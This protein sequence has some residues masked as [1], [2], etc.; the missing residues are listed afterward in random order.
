MILISCIR[1][2]DSFSSFF[3]SWYFW[4]VKMSRGDVKKAEQHLSHRLW[5][6]LTHVQQHRLSPHGSVFKS[7]RHNFPGVF[8]WDIFLYR[9][10][11]YKGNNESLF[12]FLFFFSFLFFLSCSSWGL[13][14]FVGGGGGSA[15][16]L[17]AYVSESLDLYLPETLG[18]KSPLR[19][20][21]TMFLLK[22]RKFPLMTQY[23]LK[24][25][26]TLTPHPVVFCLF[27]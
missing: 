13:L 10:W 5:I 24:T 22:L 8:I 27:K 19:S 7:C 1:I 14:K 12:L 2:M 23:F 18:C 20:L 16:A 15:R 26:T 17:W 6:K 3:N 21:I 4:S 25:V 9:T 11:F